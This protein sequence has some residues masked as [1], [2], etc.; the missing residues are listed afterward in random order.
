MCGKQKVI[1]NIIKL[2]AAS[3]ASILIASPALADRD[4]DGRGYRAKHHDNESRVMRGFA[5]SPVPL[6]MDGDESFA[7]A[8][9]VGLG[10]YIVNAQAGCAD[11]HSCPT[12]EPGHSPFQGG[13]GKLNSA[14]FLAG[15]VPFGDDVSANITPDHDGKPAGMSLEE[16][17]HTLR[18]GMHHHEGGEAEV[19]EV[20]PWPFYRHMTDRDLKAI[21]AYLTAI[22]HAHH[23]EGACEYPGQ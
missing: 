2:A 7:N 3:L 13:D 21:Y 16:F 23:I 8:A 11:C 14:N 12:Y 15:G 6:E 22:P 5:I 20:M 4:D 19:L 1:R 10:S 18:T 9:L 17:M